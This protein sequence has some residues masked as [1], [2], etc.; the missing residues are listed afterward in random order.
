MIE[1][2]I[3]DRK[4]VL[5]FVQVLEFQNMIQVTRENV[6]DQFETE[7][8]EM[9]PYLEPAPLNFELY[10]IILSQCSL[11]EDVYYRARILAN[12]DGGRKI[13]IDCFDYGHELEIQLDKNGIWS[14][15]EDEETTFKFFKYPINLMHFPIITFGLKIHGL[16]DKVSVTEE[17]REKIQT[18]FT[19]HQEFKIREVR[20]TKKFEVTLK[21]KQV[22]ELEKGTWLMS[23]LL[24]ETKV[25]C[26]FTFLEKIS[27]LFIF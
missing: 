7:A 1:P 6:R 11:V 26:L 2:D 16:T 13:Q 8:L 18:F 25:S 15:V 5:A 19:K 12:F 17:K 23:S 22:N 10:S 24:F 21:S 3:N 27:C 4:M 14:L 20:D 9:S